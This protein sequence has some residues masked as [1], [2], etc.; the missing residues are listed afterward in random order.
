MPPA[1]APVPRA[2]LLAR[3]PRPPARSPPRRQPR[4]G[5]SDTAPPGRSLGSS[6]FPPRRQASRSYSHWLRQRC[7]HTQLRSQRSQPIQLLV[8]DRDSVATPLLLAPV[9]ELSRKIDRIR[10]D[11]SR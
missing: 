8:L 6:P 10:P 11:G 2:L 9:L 3:I 4:S 5:S 7:F 1:R